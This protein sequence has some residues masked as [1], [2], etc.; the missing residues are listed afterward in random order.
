MAR[1]I[2]CLFGACLGLAGLLPPEPKPV[3]GYQLQLK[4]KQMS[5]VKVCSKVNRRK[6]TTQLCKRWGL[7]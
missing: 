7:Q 1:V 2:L 4:A 5:K 3:T 6:K